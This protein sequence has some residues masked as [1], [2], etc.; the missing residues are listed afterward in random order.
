[1]EVFYQ[2][3]ADSPLPERQRYTYREGT[4][5]SFPGLYYK[6]EVEDPTLCT[7]S[8]AS[9]MDAGEEIEICPYEPSSDEEEDEEEEVEDLEGGVI[10]APISLP[11]ITEESEESED[12]E[13]Y[14]SEDGDEDV[15]SDDECEDAVDG[16]D[17]G[18][19]EDDGDL[20]EQES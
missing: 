7:D 2:G 12:A 1:M 8:E 19:V 3:T 9:S 17:E 10:N 20:E 16:D 5:L 6:D 14:G 13:G 15:T 4:V 11:T 18:E